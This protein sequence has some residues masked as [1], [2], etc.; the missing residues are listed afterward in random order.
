MYVYFTFNNSTLPPGQADFFMGDLP[1]SD[2]ISDNLTYQNIDASNS[3]LV[4][5][6]DVRNLLWDHPS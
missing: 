3:A 1:K 4:I 5:N 2:T 6:E